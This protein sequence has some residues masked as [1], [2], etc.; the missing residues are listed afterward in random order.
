MPEA[1]N[2]VHGEGAINRV[3][4]DGATKR[5]YEAIAEFVKT[6]G[7]LH[8]DV[9][10]LG[11]EDLVRF[12]ELTINYDN[13][14][15][16]QAGTTFALAIGSATFAIFGEL[17]PKTASPAGGTS[18]PAPDPRLGANA[19]SD[20]IKKIMEKL[21]DHEFLR[22]TCKTASEFS[23][24]MMTPADILFK[25]L[26]T[27]IESK[28]TIIQTVNMSDTQGKKSTF[29]AIVQQVHQA[30]QRLM[31]AKSRGG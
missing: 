18:N 10:K 9:L 8:N 30:F 17:I 3:Y 14:M 19:A 1:I 4:G 31:E 7:G 16:W 21:G 23:K 26:T 5:V 6:M 22:S 24:N 11:R 25:S 28:R 27:E 2:R 15:R 20:A 12:M 13:Q 29:D